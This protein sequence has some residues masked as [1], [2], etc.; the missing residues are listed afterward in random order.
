MIWLNVLLRS[1]I[2]YKNV[3]SKKIIKYNRTLN[4]TIIMVFQY[5]FSI[6]TSTKFHT[7]LFPKKERTCKS[8]FMLSVLIERFCSR[9][10]VT[11]VF[12]LKIYF[13]D[14]GTESLKKKS[15]ISENEWNSIVHIAIV[16]RIMHN[17]SLQNFSKYCIVVTMSLTMVKLGKL[18]KKYKRV[19]NVAN[20]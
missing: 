7:L 11:I 3:A 15:W 12:S 5:Q 17:N 14:E 20:V 19:E 6:I 18:T 2:L 10:F 16:F 8:K 13:Q 9:I 1:N 4:R